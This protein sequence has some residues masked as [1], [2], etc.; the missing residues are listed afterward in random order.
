MKFLGKPHL[1]IM[2]AILFAGAIW[3]EVQLIKIYFVTQNKQKPFPCT[4][5]LGKCKYVCSF[6]FPSHRGIYTF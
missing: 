5:I 4:Y 2:W 1:I 6:L 3:M